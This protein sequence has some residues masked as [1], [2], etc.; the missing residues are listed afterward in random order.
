[1][2]NDP[3]FKIM[4]N[5]DR[6]AYLTET[7]EKLDQVLAGLREM[8]LHH[9]EM[10]VKVTSWIRNWE[11]HSRPDTRVVEDKIRLLKKTHAFHMGRVQFLND[12][13]AVGDTAEGDAA[14]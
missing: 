2:K 11:S 12:F 9:Y 1:M 13:F 8:R 7:P 3:V 6:Q 10:T 4:V 14:K 5:A